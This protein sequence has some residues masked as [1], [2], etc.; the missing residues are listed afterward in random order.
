[1]AAIDAG[2]S[3]ADLTDYIRVG[4]IGRPHGLQGGVVASLDQPDSATLE[5][6]RRV[7][8]ED[9]DSRCEYIIQNARPIGGRSV[10]LKL[11]GVETC[12][13][14]QALR[15]RTILVAE[16]DLAPAKANEFYDFRAIG[17]E[18][19]TTDGRR[20]GTVAE[21][22][23][24]GANDVMIVREGTTEVLIPIIADVVK[25]LD[26][27]ARQITIEAIPGLLD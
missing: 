3:S 18:V 26:F 15:G 24:T 12:A 4:R 17:C 25:N 1:M 13:A 16:R 19:T 7:V 9:G 14:A 22:F 2:A 20:L 5:T 10:R 8:L 27:T 23:A 11:E 21:I 6:A